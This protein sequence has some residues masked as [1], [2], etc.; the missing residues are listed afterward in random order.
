MATE[1]PRGVAS[2]PIRPYVSRLRKGVIPWAG[3]RG[4]LKKMARDRM[5]QATQCKL[6]GLS[7][8]LA[9]SA[10]SHGN[11]DPEPQKCLVQRAPGF[12]CRG[13][14]S[15]H[16]NHLEKQLGEMGVQRLWVQET[17]NLW[18]E[19]FNH[20]KLTEDTAW[21][22]LSLALLNSQLTAYVGCWPSQPY[23][24]WGGH[25]DVVHSEG[26]EDFTETTGVHLSLPK[27]GRGAGTSEMKMVT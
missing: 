20:I 13:R 12:P 10:W 14:L 3:K 16:I 22:M 5:I 23:E 26:E 17:P 24:L 7:S 25:T 2:L 1:R 15:A 18:L 19:L 21:W 6:E 9:K 11:K 27:D 4:K 8:S